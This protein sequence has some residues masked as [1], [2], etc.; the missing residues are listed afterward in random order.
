MKREA[1]LSQSYSRE[2]NPRKRGY[3]KKDFN[4]VEFENGSRNVKYPLVDWK[5]T[6]RQALEYCYSKGF[7]WN[8]LY[9]KFHRVSCWCCPLSRIGELRVLYNE[10]PELWS[11]LEEMDRKSFRRFRSDYSVSDLNKRFANEFTDKGD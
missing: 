3:T 9:E 7:D 4:I 1:F 2:Y 6:E 5:I 11:K 10:F 8:G